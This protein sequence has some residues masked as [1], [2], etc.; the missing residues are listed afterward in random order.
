M[1]DTLPY[2]SLIAHCLRNRWDIDISRERKVNSIFKGFLGTF[3]VC[4]AALG[5]GANAASAVPA[6]SISIPQQCG[7]ALDFAASE[8]C[9]YLKMMTGTDYTVTRDHNAQSSIKLQVDA[10]LKPDGYRIN[11]AGGV[12]TIHGGNS[13][14]CLYGA[15]AF[16]HELGC[17]WPLPGQEYEIIPKRKNVSWSR[18]ELKSEPVVRRRGLVIY[19]S[20][21]DAKPCLDLVDFMTKNGFNFLYFCQN[22]DSSNTMT[23][24]LFIDA[25]ACREM[26]FAF[27]GHLLPALLPRDMFAAH[28]EYFRMENGVRTPNLNMCPSSTD[29][30]DIIAGNAKRYTDIISRYSNPETLHMYTDDLWTGGWCSCPKCAGLTDADQCLKITND[31]AERLP[32]GNAKLAYAAYHSTLTPPSTIKPSSRVRLVA[33]VR[34]RCYKHALGECEVNKKYLQ[35]CKDLIK[36]FPNE[37]EVFEYYGDMILFRWLPVPLHPVIGKDVQA[38]IDAGADG[39]APLNFERYSNWAYGPNSYVFGRVLWRGKGDPKDIEDYCSDVYGPAGAHMKEYFDMLFELTATAMETCGYVIP[40]DLRS[41]PIGQPFAKSH[42]AQLLP[43][44]S[45]DHLNA[46]EAKLRAALVDIPDAYRSR[47]EDQR[48]LF[49]YAR[50]ETRNIYTQV[51]LAAEYTD[52]MSSTG[53]DADRRRVI[54]KLEAA[55]P[56]Y[57][58]S[59]NDASSVVLCG[60]PNLTGRIIFE[61]S[62]A[63]RSMSWEPGDLKY[64]LD[65]LKA[66]VAVSGEQ[67]GE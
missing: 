17:R 52:A 13:R 46:I 3:L 63:R 11:S 58:D 12:L 55:M 41:A 21:S 28:P 29:A 35:Y 20:D 26:G 8:L 53:T 33:A 6:C 49:N 62:R 54:A 64:M 39:I 23:N 32:L 61:D 7:K 25:V 2:L 65:Q 18:P 1:V 48:R 36:A 44:I 9:R 24:Q 4:L 43:L 56:D 66:K 60:P 51:S 27:G 47:V 10:N 37:P 16:L 15:Y 45:D 19:P 31:V 34:E 59:F 57:I 5:S 14:G 38:Y 30:V 50:L 42:A 67:G 40:T 22:G